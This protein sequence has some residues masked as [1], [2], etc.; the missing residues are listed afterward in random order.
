MILN[1]KST[2]SKVCAVVV[3]AL[4][5]SLYADDYDVRSGEQI[6][7]ELDC[8]C[9]KA[10]SMAAR[11]RHYEREGDRVFQHEKASYRRYHRLAEELCVCLH[12]VLERVSE[13]EKEYEQLQVGMRKDNTEEA[14]R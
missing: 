4:A 14:E 6:Q 1:P 11:I 13:L 10:E 9:C 3:L 8:L 7:A 2:I 12:R 5:A